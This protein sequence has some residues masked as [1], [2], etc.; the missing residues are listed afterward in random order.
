MVKKKLI[1]G[2]WKMNPLTLKEAE[3]IF[4]AISK[5][6]SSIGKC[7]AVI[8]PPFPFIE[9][10]KKSSRKITLGAQ[11]AFGEMSAT[12]KGVGPYTGEVSGAMLHDLGVR[13]V[14]LGHSER[15]ALGEKDEE[16]NRKVKA[17]LASGLTPVLCV[18]ERERDESH[19]YFNIVK[20]QIEDCLERVVKNS[21][22]KIAIA[23]EP[24]WSISTTV[25][26]RDATPADFKEMAIY[27]RKVLSDKFGAKTE[28]PRILYGG[29]V[30]P[31]NAY[32][33]L[34]EGEADGLLVGRDS[35]D[36]EKFGEILK[37]CDQ[38]GI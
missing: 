24:V 34:V 26:R 5:S 2:N 35:L 13:Y 31:K 15:R 4:S 25:G 8:C 11:D 17:C 7:S 14:I 36:P 37:I 3:K 27:I 6:V 12:G 19:E 23:Y 28:M 16:I 30:S 22:G 32:G 38:S 18:G 1:I 9:K 29:S 10:L 20:K 33:F 21:L